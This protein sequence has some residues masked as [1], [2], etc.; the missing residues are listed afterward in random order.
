MKMI[1]LKKEAAFELWTQQFGK[2]QKAV[3]FSGREIV[4]AA[5]ND[6]NSNYGWNVDHIRPKSKGGKTE[7]NNLIC[8][9]ILTNDEKAGKYPCF[10]ANEKEFEVQKRQNR[11]EII[12]KTVTLKEEKDET[13]NFLD[14][15]QG[16]ACWKYCKFNRE[17]VFVGYAKIKVEISNKSDQ[18]L[19]RYGK[20]LCELFNTESIYAQAAAADEINGGML[21]RSYNRSYIFTVIVADVPM[22]EDIENLLNDCVTLN[23]YSTYFCSNTGIES[24]RIVCGME[25]YDSY[26]KMFLNYKKDI[27][28]KRVPFYD[29]LIIDELVKIY[30]SAKEELK[31]I[32]AREGFYPYNFIFTQL[33]KNLKKYV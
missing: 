14:G 27:V 33:N 7:E 25:C 17:N 26:F 32:S 24:I 20:F 5:Y 23:T 21:R 19:E 9:H 1:N 28:E 29:S 10:R 13:V 15:K 3:D 22:K 4:K 18:L 8:C 30:T 16:L 31:D 11:Y 6:R 12:L 2:S